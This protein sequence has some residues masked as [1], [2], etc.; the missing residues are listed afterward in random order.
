[1]TNSWT[2]PPRISRDGSDAAT[3]RFSAVD[4]A[5]PT[6]RIAAVPYPE[7]ESMSEA[8]PIVIRRARPSLFV[9]PN[10]SDQEQ[11]ISRDIGVQR[12]PQKQEISRNRKI[13][14][15]LPKWDPLPPGEIHVIH[16]GPRHSSP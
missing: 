16:R 12:R 8:P 3:Q 10:P 11:V 1:M 13:A 15:N 7:Q 6:E 9:P 4:G 2:P 5:A 14:G